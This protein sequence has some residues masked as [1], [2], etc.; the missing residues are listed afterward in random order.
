MSYLLFIQFQDNELVRS[1]HHHQFTSY[2]QFES[3]D[4]LTLLKL[5]LS[6]VKVSLKWLLCTFGITL[7]VCDILYSFCYV[8]T[9]YAQTRKWPFLQEALVFFN[10]KRHFKT[11]ARTCYGC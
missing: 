9:F 6:H 11:G 7:V 1:H 2:L 5:K 8:K 3:I 10:G 4:I